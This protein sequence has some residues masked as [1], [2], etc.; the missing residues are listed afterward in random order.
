MV[1][2]NLSLSV[3]LVCLFRNALT[4]P[5]ERAHSQLSVEKVAM[6]KRSEAG[7]EI[8]G[9]NFPDPSIMKVGSTWYA[10]A[11]RTIGSDIHIQV[12]SSPDFNTW[13]IET[14]SDGTQRDALPTLPAWV[15]ASSPNTWAPDVSLLVSH[16]NSRL[17]GIQSPNT[18]R[19]VGRW[20]LRDVLLS[21][22]C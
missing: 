9:A 1:R 12:A 11:T 21:H 3:A 6:V 14:N 15:Y 20:Y 17:D 10:F 22:N 4:L 2:Y 8:G 19:C 13:T 5:V 16:H 7:P 18:Q